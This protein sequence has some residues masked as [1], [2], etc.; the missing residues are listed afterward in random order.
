MH[1]VLRVIDRQLTFKQMLWF[2]PI[3]LTL[4][5]IEEAWTMPH[6]VMA[7]ATLIKENLPVNIDIHF[8]P[9]QLLYSL[10][11]A[12]VVPF[13]VTILCVN[14]G[15]QSWRLYLLFLLQAIVLLNVF[16]PHIAASIRM[17]EYN[18]GVVTAVCVNLPFSLYV[19]RR[20]Y[21]EQYLAPP[22][23]VSLFL[24]ALVVYP[25]VAW[26]LHFAGEWIAK[27]L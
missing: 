9:A 10:L 18:P 24:L 15:K 3:V 17:R 1:N 16:I 25:P 23:F 13:I 5:N 19:F 7:N 2:I 8:T 22:Q 20:T 26:I 27:A 14:G 12:T 11:L 21:R 6:W 4:H